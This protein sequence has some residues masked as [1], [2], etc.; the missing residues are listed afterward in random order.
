[1]REN[2][3]V[4]LTN[5]SAI[6]RNKTDFYPTP[7]N[8]TEALMQVVDLK[9][10][11]VL[12]PA[13]GQM[14][15]VEVLQKY[16]KEVDYFDKYDTFSGRIGDFLES[17]NGG[18]DWVITNPPFNLSVEFIEHAISEHK[19]NVAMLLKS[20][21]WHS[22]KRKKLFDKHKPK[23]VYPLTWRPDFHFGSK[24]GSPTMDV[25]WVVWGK[26]P[27]TITEY[28]PLSKGKQE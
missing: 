11:K 1:M 16:A 27:S 25:M 18:Y 12:E 28:Q 4:V 22:A 20:Q 6:D 9:D 15:M 23:G 2:L 10:C 8:V 5:A 3:G 13:C 21:Y 19:C 24:G 14:H 17:E 7:S 26:E